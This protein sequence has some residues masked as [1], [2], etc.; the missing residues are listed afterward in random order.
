[1][2]TRSLVCALAIT[3]LAAC[4]SKHG[5]GGTPDASIVCGLFG[6]NCAVGGDCCSGTCDPQGGCT[7]NP[8]TCS[9]AGTTCASNTD[10][11]SVSCV[12]GVCQGSCTADNGS[13]TSNG[14]CCGGL[15]T[16]GTCAP[17]NT[18]CK[19]AGNP[20]GANGEC[21]GGL[22]NSAGTCGNASWCI[23]D[24]NSCSHDA[25]CC[26]GICTIAQ[27]GTIGTCS[28][29]QTGA[30]DCSAG[31]DGALC[32]TCGDC[33]SALCEI[34]PPTGVKVCQPAEGCRVDGDTCHN[35]SDCCG[36]PNTGLPGA[37]NVICLGESGQALPNGT[38]TIGVC[39]N[40]TGCNPEGDTCHY[41]TAG[42][43]CGNSSK[44]N[45]CCA[46][47]SGKDCCILDALGAPRCNA[48]TTCVMVGSNCAFSSDCCN[49]EPCVPN[50]SGQLVCGAAC[51][52]TTGVCTSTADCCNGLTCV[53]TPGQ[54]YGTCGGSTGSGS[55]SGSS[56]CPQSGQPCSSTMPCCANLGLTCD[57]ASA[58]GTP[59]ANDGTACICNGNIIQ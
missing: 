42:Y 59:C 44:R 53:F 38:D 50:G 3:W 22:C 23:V 1:M 30:T 4:G 25:E 58:P 5:T 55:G 54:T 20:C 10:C 48:V 37:G 27:G 15:C 40:P 46:C 28:Q 14:Q 51:V 32:N 36:A 43:A 29:P 24:G 11:C 13:C 31:I 8:T 26:G 6:A 12:S 57:E 35:T 7:V 52:N 45:D 33:C 34:Y 47:I 56:T 39:R 9:A 49:G 16:N 41:K 21:C 17:L 2:N 19:S 18:T